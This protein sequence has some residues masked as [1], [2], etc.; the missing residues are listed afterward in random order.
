MGLGAT[1]SS[2]LG[3]GYSSASTNV[4]I[5]G[6]TVTVLGSGTAMI[7]ASQG[8]D[9]NYV[10]ATPVTNTLTIGQGNA[11]VTISGTSATYDGTGKSV[12]VVTTPGGLSNSVTYNGSLNRPTNAGSYSVVATINDGNY[13][14]SG[15]STL[16]I[17]QASNAISFPGLISMTNGQSLILTASSVSGLPVQYASSSTNVRIAG[18]VL[19]ALHNGSAS[20]VATAGNSNWQTVALT[21][22]V[23][24]KSGATISITA[25]NVTYT[26]VAKP[27]KVTTVPPNLPI[28]V[29]YTGIGDT[30]YGP[31]ISSPTN[32]GS[33]NVAASVNESNVA[34]TGSAFSIQT[35]T[36]AVTTVTIARTN[37][38]Y[39]GVVAP[40]TVSTV[41]SGIATRVAYTGIG[42][43][44]Y[45]LTSNAPVN[46]GTYA[47]TALIT[48]SNRLG[49]AASVL[50]ITPKLTAVTIGGTSA[51][52][53]G[54]AKPVIVTT[55]PSGVT[56]LITYAGSGTTTYGPTSNAPVNA[57]TYAVSA[58]IMDPNRTG[59]KT[60][61]LTI[62]RGRQTITFTQPAAVTNGVSPFPLVAKSSSGL[63]VMFSSLSTNIAISG[64]T[65]TVLGTGV[66]S[67]TAAQ[68]GNSNWIAAASL[69]QRLTVSGPAATSP[70]VTN[71]IPGIAVTGSIPGI[72]IRPGVFP[73]QCPTNAGSV[74]AWGNGAYG[75][76]NIP[77][78]L[79]NVV[80]IS[81]RGIHNLALLARGG[82]VSW[83]WNGYGQT[84]VPVEATNVVQVAS[85]M[86]F[87]AA[88]CSD[89]R[90]IE[91]GDDSLGQIEVPDSVTNAVQIAAGS[92]HSLALLADGRVL[93][94]G[95]N[96]Y[97][98]TDVPDDAT[99]VVQVAGGYFHSVA[100]KADGTVK[101]WGDNT[102]GE[103][104]VPLGLTNVVRIVTG[105]NHTVALKSDGSVVVWGWNNAGQTNV[106]VGL[107]GVC[108]IAS[109]G[110][111]VFALTTNG[112]LV[113]WGDNSYGQRKPP[114]GIV[115]IYEMVLGLYHALGLK[116]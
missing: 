91:W 45:G 38:V 56:T 59:L 75:Q 110:N 39:S 53:T 4:S 74:V 26:G 44:T 12:T 35:I 37:A 84:N 85:G 7:V 19:T 71:Q 87:S 34:Y 5:S 99:N 80:Q 46:A 116:R 40:V 72:V 81:S 51:T 115:R 47:V 76:T 57:G 88:L 108:E 83:G 111:T 24:I 105:L 63:P 1:A 9:S 98:Q 50:T 102:Y 82:V 90:V 86:G 23:T 114:T 11:G 79:T 68:P 58:Q 113:T 89:G 29:T 106:P 2:G 15:T 78:G 100:L 14:G 62:A 95:W 27:V 41:P 20:V 3:V 66:A 17:G 70:T 64:G 16:T 65:V 107:S 32:V 6:S 96:A 36:P 92:D 43:T 69:I 101:A 52:Y 55:V 22:M 77:F 10:A 18:N 61:A 28:T 103:T 49:S 109:G 33:Y 42:T 30:I 25:T 48:D 60:A 73:L 13:A 93:A 54:V 21:N 67:I 31:S 8:G 97:G 112:T 94:W 104:S